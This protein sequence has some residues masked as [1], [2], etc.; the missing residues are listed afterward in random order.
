MVWVIPFGLVPIQVNLNTLCQAPRSIFDPGADVARRAKFS[1][2]ADVALCVQ[3]ST[4]R[5][6]IS[7]GLRQAVA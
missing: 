2:S 6:K 3:T 4:Q 5:A 1:T 7:T